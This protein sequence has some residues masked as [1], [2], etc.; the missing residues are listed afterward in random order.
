LSSNRYLQQVDADY[1]ATVAAGI[2]RTPTFV[3]NGQPFPGVLS[4]ADFRQIF[5]EVAPD[6]DF[7]S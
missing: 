2:N 7:D 4:V 6:V 3:I 1:N 5:A